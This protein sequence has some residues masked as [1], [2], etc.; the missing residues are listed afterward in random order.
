M[1]TAIAGGE[2][3]AGSIAVVG[4]TQQYTFTRLGERLVRSEAQRR[5]CRQRLAARDHDLWSQ[6][7]TGR[8]KLDRHRRHLDERLLRRTAHRRRNV[9]GRRAG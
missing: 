7:A 1:L 3:V 9:H 6:R 4:Q 8:T 2:T 5:Q